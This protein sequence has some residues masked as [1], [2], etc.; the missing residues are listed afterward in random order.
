MKGH[1][2]MSSIKLPPPKTAMTKSGLFLN[3]QEAAF[4]EAYSLTFDKIASVLHAGFVV[5]I[6][7]PN[8]YKQCN[9]TA[10][11]LLKNP[12]IIERLREL[13]AE[14]QLNDSV[15]DLELASVIAQ[16]AELPSKIKAIDI[17]NKLNGRYEQVIRHKFE[18]LS[19]EELEERLA[20][21]IS[22]VIG[23]PQGEGGE[24]E[25]EEPEIISP[26]PEAGG[27][28]QDGGEE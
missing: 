13:L 24:D 4:A 14:L 12:K 21:T 26:E 19:D 7:N 5:K 28:H 20:E 17:Y 15:V 18:G 11:R 1:I 27:I 22:G 8:W 6:D 23:A 10:N 9:S 25:G 3:A 16:S 2:E